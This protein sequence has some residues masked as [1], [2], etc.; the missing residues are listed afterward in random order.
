MLVHWTARGLNYKNI[1]AAN[2][3]LNLQ[4][5]LAIFKASN[6]RLPARHAEELTNFISQ[7]FVRRAAKNLES[8]VHAWT[9][10]LAWFLVSVH[11]RLFFRRCRKSSHVLALTYQ[12]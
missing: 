8:I 7:R 12:S 2:V 11:V 5:H 10:R 4:V 3:L 6:V 9:L 1:G